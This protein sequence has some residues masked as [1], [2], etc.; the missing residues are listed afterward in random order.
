MPSDHHRLQSWSQPAALGLHLEKPQGLGLH[1]KSALTRAGWP[2]SGDSR[3]SVSSH[4]SRLELV[5]RQQALTPECSLLSFY[6][7]SNIIMTRKVCPCRLLRLGSMKQEDPSQQGRVCLPDSALPASLQ[8]ET[9][10]LH[11]LE[12]LLGVK[13]SFSQNSCSNA[14]MS[15]MR[16][17]ALMSQFL[18]VLASSFLQEE[19]L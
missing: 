11:P 12:L 14:S 4:E 10:C 13:V 15:L 1:P 2:R 7:L 16:K 8:P 5:R 6:C 18:S 3:Y 9:L 17:C 19:D